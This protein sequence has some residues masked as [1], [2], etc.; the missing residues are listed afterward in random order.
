MREVTG[1]PSQVTSLATSVSLEKRIE[2]DSATDDDKALLK[3]LKILKRTQLKA[4]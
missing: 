2:V 3:E 1:T 4:F